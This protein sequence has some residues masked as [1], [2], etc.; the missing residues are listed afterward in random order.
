MKENTY[1]EKKKTHEEI[2]EGMENAL[3][4]I[5]GVIDECGIDPKEVVIQELLDVLFGLKHHMED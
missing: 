1:E 5:C 2:K 3:Q 4:W